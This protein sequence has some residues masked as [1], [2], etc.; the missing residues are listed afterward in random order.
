MAPPEPATLHIHVRG[1]ITVANAVL[2]V[3]RSRLCK[4]ACMHIHTCR[5]VYMYAHIP[6]PLCM[7]MFVTYMCIYV[8][9]RCVCVHMYIY[10]CIHIYIYVC[11]YVRTTHIPN[12]MLIFHRLSVKV[13]TP[14]RSWHRRPSSQVPPLAPRARRPHPPRGSRAVR[15]AFTCSRRPGSLLLRTR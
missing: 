14:L 2:H 3:R 8:Y 7:Q 6:A 12:Y 9:I 1:Y 10:I 11:T 5:H 13:R 15:P 4:H